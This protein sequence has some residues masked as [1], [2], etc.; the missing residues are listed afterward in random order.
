M[1]TTLLL[2]DETRPAKLMLQNIATTKVIV[3]EAEAVAGCN[4]DRW[5]HPCVG[6]NEHK[7]QPKAEFPIPSAAKQAT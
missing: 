3:R 6:C 5:G 2:N 4:C 1:K 7:V